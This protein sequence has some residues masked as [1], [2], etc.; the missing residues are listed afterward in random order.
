[1]NTIGRKIINNGIVFFVFYFIFFVSTTYSQSPINPFINTSKGI[2]SLLDIVAGIVVTLAFLFFFWNLT[3]FIRES[4][5]ATLQQAKQKMGWAA[6]AIF[7]MVS[8]WGVV[9]FISALTGIDR[10]KASDI[11]L[12]GFKGSSFYIF[13]T[14]GGGGGGGGPGGGGGGPGGGGCDTSCIINQEYYKCLSGNTKWRCDCLK[15]IDTKYPS[16]RGLSRCEKYGY[17][18]CLIEGR[19]ITHCNREF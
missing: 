3:V 12:P 4:D 9:Q 2:Q 17:A 10:G 13:G 15:I 8:V 5:R 18:S 1:M 6:L 19:E 16:Y 7:V 14:G 11:Q